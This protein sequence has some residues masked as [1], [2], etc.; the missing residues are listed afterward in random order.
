MFSSY[1]YRIEAF[2]KKK[3]FS[4]GV[5]YK[6]FLGNNKLQIDK[7]TFKKK[8]EIVGTTLADTINTFK[9]D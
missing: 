7:K 2:L 1:S 4:G 6:L 9:G 3:R 8:R 5:N